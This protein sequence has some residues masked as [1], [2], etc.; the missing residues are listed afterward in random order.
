MTEVGPV[1][2]RP[3]RDVERNLVYSVT[4]PSGLVAT[5]PDALPAESERPTPW[6]F[7]LRRRT[8]GG[9]AAS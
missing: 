1:V 9:P 5:G 4:L 7:V 6:P 8:G 2:Q 3:G